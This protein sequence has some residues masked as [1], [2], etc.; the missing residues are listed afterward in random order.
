MKRAIAVHL[1]E[2]G[3]PL[4]SLRYD[5]KT[6]F[7]VGTGW[8]YWPGNGVRGPDIRDLIGAEK[9]CRPTRPTERSTIAVVSVYAGPPTRGA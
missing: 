8:R 4:G 1:G 9:R 6:N 2:R 5:L 3:T 7:N